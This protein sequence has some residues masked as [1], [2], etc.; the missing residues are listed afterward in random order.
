MSSKFGKL[1]TKLMHG[2]V[3]GF[4]GYEIGSKNLKNDD[5]KQELKVI[6][7]FTK[8]EQSEKAEMTHIIM[9]SILIIMVALIVRKFLNIGSQITK[10]M[11]VIYTNQMPIN[12]IQQQ[13]QINANI[14]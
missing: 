5:I 3:I 6:E 8:I 2:A 9:I 13:N 11:R 10:V 12:A 4:T 7:K 14:P 1:F